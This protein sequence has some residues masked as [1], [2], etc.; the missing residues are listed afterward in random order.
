MPLPMAALYQPPPPSLDRVRSGPLRAG[1]LR[2][3][4]GQ[5]SAGELTSPTSAGPLSTKDQ[6]VGSPSQ[7]SSRSVGT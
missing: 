2:S 4:S 1:L 7:P 5:L 6:V 3:E